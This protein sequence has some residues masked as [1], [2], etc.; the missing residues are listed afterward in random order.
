MTRIRADK[1]L[2]KPAKAFQS[3]IHE[4]EDSYDR[5]GFRNKDKKIVIKG[6][7]RFDLV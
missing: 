6:M 3:K 7:V 5:R 1:Y 2:R 4:G